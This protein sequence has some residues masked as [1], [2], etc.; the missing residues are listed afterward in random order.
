MAALGEALELLHGAPAVLDRAG[1]A[2]EREA[3]AAQEDACVEL[4]LQRAQ[5]RLLVRR[6]RGRETVRKVDLLSHVAGSASRTCSE[7]RRP[8]ARPATS[9]IA[10]GMTLPRSRWLLAPAC[11]IARLTI[12]ASCTSSSSA[13][14]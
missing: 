9:A 11:A 13:G 7:T 12:S 1:L 5:Q 4:T 6:E 2:V 14:R 8:S 3:V 10:I